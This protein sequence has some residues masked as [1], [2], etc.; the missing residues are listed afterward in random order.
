[1]LSLL[2]PADPKA[3]RFDDAARRLDVSAK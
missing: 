2:T 3:A 1:V